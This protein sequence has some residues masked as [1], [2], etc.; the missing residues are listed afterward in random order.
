MSGGECT[1][2]GTDT[3]VVI[4]LSP[5]HSLVLNS[6]PFYSWT[7]LS[8]YCGRACECVLGAGGGGGEKSEDV[9]A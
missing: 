6:C 2:C 4:H 5:H 1:C 3:R 9:K 7:L 8:S